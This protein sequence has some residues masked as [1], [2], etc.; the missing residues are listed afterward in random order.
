MVVVPPTVVTEILFKPAVPAGVFAVTMVPVLVKTVADVPP[1]FTLVAPVK[2]VPVIVIVVPPAIGPYLGDKVAIVGSATYVNAAVL[3][4]TPPAVVTTTS[5][6]P[7]VPAGVF[8]VI[9]VAVATTLVAATPPTVTVEPVKL[10]PAIVIDV[11]AVSGPD[12]GD[13]LAMVGRA[14]Y[15]NALALVAVPPMVVTAT[16]CAP[17]VPAG[18]VAVMTVAV[19][20]KIVAATLPTF[21]LVAPVKLVPVIVIVVPPATGP[22]IGATVVMVGSATYVNAAVLVA[23][24]PAVV[25]TTSFAPTALAGVSAV[26]EVELTT[27]TLLAA[28]PPTFTVVA[29]S[30][31]LVPAIVI[32]VPAVSG[33]DGGDTLVMVGSA[34]YVNALALVAVPPIVV[35][36]TLCAPAVPLGVVA[37]MV[38]VELVKT[39]A[40]ALP[41]F[42]LVALVK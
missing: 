23:T 2:L 13:T 32:D 20:V 1:T 17:A 12:V 34:T 26:M 31:K 38:V 16:L 15:V 29:P 42:T 25:T 14:T 5:F 41:T 9:E 4:A 27:R 19:L 18:V 40:A 39:V 3:V 10:V 22:E 33:P 7:A 36:S 30:T 8:A 35:T 21:T 28:T 24:P 11:P 6:A 37:V